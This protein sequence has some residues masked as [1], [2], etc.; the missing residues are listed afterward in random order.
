MSMST[1]VAALETGGKRCVHLR[2]RISVV[3]PMSL[4]VSG[5]TEHD[6]LDADGWAIPRKSDDQAGHFDYL[7]RVRI[8]VRSVEL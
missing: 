4:Q 3:K 2:G 8:A 1:V 7:G 6:G 5:F